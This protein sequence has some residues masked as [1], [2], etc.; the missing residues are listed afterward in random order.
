LGVFAAACYVGPDLLAR[1]RLPPGTM[2]VVSFPLGPQHGEQSD[3]L[4]YLLQWDGRRRL[5]VE[6]PW[7][8][9]RD[10]QGSLFAVAKSETQDFVAFSHIPH[11]AHEVHLQCYAHFGIGGHELTEIEVPP[12]VSLSEFLPR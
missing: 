10:Q 8:T 11:N 6:P 7:T 4:K 3:L 12:G 1:W 9:S 2:P 5:L